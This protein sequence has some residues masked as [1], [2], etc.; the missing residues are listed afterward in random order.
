MNDKRLTTLHLRDSGLLLIQKREQGR[1]KGGGGRRSRRDR[2]YATIARDGKISR[3][4]GGGG[5]TFSEKDDTGDG[6]AKTA[7]ELLIIKETLT[8]H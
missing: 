8:P 2:V 4:G 6:T 1:R 7:H 3:G 5:E